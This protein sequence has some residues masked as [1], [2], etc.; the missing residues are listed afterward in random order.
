ME[1]S[2]IRMNVFPVSPGDEISVSKN[3]TV[4]V[5]PTIHRVESLGY[6]IFSTKKG[7][8]LP[9]YRCL[10]NNEIQRL[11]QSG[12]V[13]T[14][15]D[16][17]ELEL[18][19]TGD[20]SI[21]MFQLPQNAF[22]LSSPILITEMTYIDGDRSKANFYGHIHIEDIIENAHLFE[23]VKEI[24]FV[25]FSQRYSLSQIIQRLQEKLPID[26]QCKVQCSLFSFGAKE[27]L[28][29][30]A[31]P[32]L[33]PSVTSNIAG[34]GWG[35]QGTGSTVTTTSV[36]NENSSSSVVNE[37][38]SIEM[39]TII[40]EPPQQPLP[41]RRMMIHKRIQKRIQQQRHRSN[42]NKNS[43]RQVVITTSQS[44]LF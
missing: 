2:S 43:R 29:A 6:A 14:S 42:K 32:S 5:I 44:T 16:T 1:G 28:T 26:L 25:H 12:T 27:Y 38:T 20:T 4:V 34:W 35:L 11:K 37:T 24:I 8:L 15:P 41:T 21:E 39:S 18:V 9:E 13:I 3:L 23:N 30:L 31:D 7:S 10:N 40:E 36:N 17:K 22:I 33:A 19:Y